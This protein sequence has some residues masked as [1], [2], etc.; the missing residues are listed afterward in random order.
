MHK[1]LYAKLRLSVAVILVVFACVILTSMPASAKQQTSHLLFESQFDD[2][3]PAEE[4][5]SAPSALVLDLNTG[6]VLF[7]KNSRQEYG[8]ASLNKLASLI[9][10]FEALQ[11]GDVAADELV[12]VSE[13]A[14]AANVPGSKMFLEVG[15]EVEFSKLM[16]G[17]IVPS[18]N[19]ASIALAE[20][21]AGSEEA[22][23]TRMNQL[24]ERLN[25][26]DTV[27]G[28]VHGLPAEHQQTTVYD[29]GKLTRHLCLNYPQALEITS[30]R[31]FT[32]GQMDPQKN[33]NKLLSRDPRVLG[34]KT[35]WTP[36]S[37]YH[38][39]AVAR[40]HDEFYA[41]I[42]M[43]I[44]A[45]EDVPYEVG[46]KRRE[47]DAH[48]LLKWAF[49]TFSAHSVDISA[50][51][52]EGVPVYGG[53]QRQVDLQIEPESAV[54]TIPQGTDD[55]L[56]YTYSVDDPLWAPLREDESVGHAAVMWQ[57]ED[58][59]DEVLKLGDWQLYPSQQVD[60]GGWLRVIW[61][62]IV[63]FFRNLSG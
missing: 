28:T 58:E 11:Q 57:P 50:M 37:G 14:W 31:S 63:L 54:V 41:A 56:Q 24:A 1:L 8:P 61:D 23:V 38:L 53:K 35:G 5:V 30:Q 51:Q 16:T 33:R 32:Y 12:T 26:G 18:G 29:M 13:R 20:H 4:I 6:A 19:D 52:P 47:D 17:M 43:G 39:A 48:A 9:L 40:E 55:H 34:L 15:D 60:R 21:L 62:R 25:L 45:G 42:V 46:A 3:L 59:G 10:A 44:G 7:E 49:D 27:F 22:F 2:H 36:D